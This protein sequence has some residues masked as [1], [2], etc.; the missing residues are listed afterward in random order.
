[1]KAI[2]KVGDKVFDYNY[3]WGEV[4]K[5]DGFDLLIVKFKDRNV[6]YETNGCRPGSQL[7][8]L[9]FT[10]YTLEGFSQ[11]RPIN[12]EDYIGKWG[13]FWRDEGEEYWVIR[14]LKNFKEGSFESENSS[15]YNNFKPLTEE[16]IK[17]LEL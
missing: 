9:S 4:A 17:I 15:W 3:G 8:I 13:K 10:E 5:F 2:F 12:Y 7:P 6:G 11:E 14:R 1:M 16:Q